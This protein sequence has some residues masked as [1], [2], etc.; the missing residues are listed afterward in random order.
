M[1]GGPYSAMVQQAI[2]DL[3]T[4]DNVWSGSNTFDGPVVFNGGVSGAVSGSGAAG[5]VA[6]WDGAESLSSDANLLYD[7]SILRAP[8]FALSGPGIATAG[9]VRLGNGVN[10]RIVARNAIDTGDIQLLALLASGTIELGHFG[11]LLRINDQPYP[12]QLMDFGRASD[13]WAKG[14]FT[15]LQFGTVSAIGAETVTGFITITDASGATRKV[16]VVS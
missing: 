13:P 15:D 1:T 9:S 14:Y 6:V 4:G 3:L 8:V 16:A 12:V 2:D 5:R 11:G 10:S 7:G